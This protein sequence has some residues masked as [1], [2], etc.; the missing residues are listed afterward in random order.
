MGQQPQ[1][2]RCP[3][4]ASAIRAHAGRTRS[5]KDLR[6]HTNGSTPVASCGLTE[7]HGWIQHPAQARVPGAGGPPTH[8]RLARRSTKDVVMPPHA[9]P[10]HRPSACRCHTP[11]AVPAAQPDCD[12]HRPRRRR[13]LGSVRGRPWRLRRGV[14]RGRGAP[15]KKK[16]DALPPPRVRS[17]DSS[18]TGRLHGCAS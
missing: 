17:A 4:A 5:L 9:V 2:E 16:T 3:E 8:H 18:P 1:A 14:W 10:R 15:E 6:N 11:R 7:A 13:G 12:L